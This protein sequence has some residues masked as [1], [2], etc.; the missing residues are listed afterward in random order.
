MKKIK[1]ELHLIVL[2]NNINLEEVEDNIN[3]RFKVV[4][5]ISVPSLEETYGQEK[6]LEVL[7]IIYRFEL[8]THH[9]V[10]VSKKLTMCLKYFQRF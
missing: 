9:L 10:S 1:E 6:R 7:N 5:K 2:W 8:P 4:K 3:K